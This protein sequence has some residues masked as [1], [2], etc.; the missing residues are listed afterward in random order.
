MSAPNWRYNA[1]LFAALTTT[2]TTTGIYA[3][4]NDTTRL[5]TINFAES[6]VDV[7]A[8]TRYTPA[9]G[10][11]VILTWIN[12]QLR[13]T[14]PAR[15]RSS[16][17]VIISVANPL[18][19]VAANSSIYNMPYD[20]NLA[21]DLAIN[22][23]VVIDWDYRNGYVKSKLSTAGAN[24]DT[25]PRLTVDQKPFTLNFFAKQSGSYKDGKWWTQDVRA[26][27]DDVAGWFYGN[28]IRKT[29]RNDAYISSVEIYLPPRSTGGALPMIGRHGQDSRPSGALSVSDAA[30][31]GDR[32]GWVRLPVAWAE[33]WRD[34]AGGVA[35]SHG[36]TNIYKGIQANRQSGKLRIR[37]RQ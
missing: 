35:L 12:K 29:L 14:G 17:G 33:G 13:L 23:P 32:N 19:G 25:P 5:H 8:S 22:D 2:D 34:S 18:V 36:G 31:R 1:Q 27:P 21:G 4:Y 10:E 20:V 24:A 15:A 7:K 26:D 16:E 11:P 3:G 6:S 9:I 30:T 37:G 28:V